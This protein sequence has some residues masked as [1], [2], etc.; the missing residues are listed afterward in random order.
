[1]GVPLKDVML[2]GPDLN[3]TLLGVRIQFKELAFAFT[4]DIE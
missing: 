1:M 2:T 4:A 3:I